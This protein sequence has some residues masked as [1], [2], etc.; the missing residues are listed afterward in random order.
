M[1]GGIAARYAGRHDLPA[2]DGYLL[3]A[4]HLGQSSPTTRSE[5]ASTDAHAPQV[6]KLHVRRLIGLAMLNVVRF[7]ALN[8]LDT[9]YFDLPGDSTGR[10]Y[11]FRALASMAPDDYRIALTAD[12]K[13][14][15]VIVGRHD[16]AFRADAYPAVV[17]LHRNGTAVVVPGEDHDGI[18][19]NK[20]A[21]E[22]VHAWAASSH[23]AS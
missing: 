9:L 23:L 7:R 12:E 18:T 4:P 13:P 15:L 5:P 22:S 10:A 21:F 8:G 14:L 16:E 19:R 1:G 6:L 2:V 3:F 11:T 17:K 20:T